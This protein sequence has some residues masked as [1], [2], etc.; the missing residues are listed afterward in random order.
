M[1]STDGRKKSCPHCPGRVCYNSTV[2]VCESKRP[3]LLS[4][5]VPQTGT[6]FLLEGPG[7]CRG[8]PGKRTD[9]AQDAVCE[10]QRTASA[11]QGK[12]YQC[13]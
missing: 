12:G 2:D 5:P 13:G 6:P 10:P 8:F 9:R 1:E 11:K 7:E 4:E 3:F